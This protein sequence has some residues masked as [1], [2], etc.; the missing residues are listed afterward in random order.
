MSNIANATAGVSASAASG[1]K[2]NVF[3]NNVDTFLK[4]LTTQLKNQ[5]PTSPMDTTA[6]TSQLVQFSQ[7]EQMMNLGTSFKEVSGRIDDG[8][9]VQATNLVGRR[10]E[11]ETPAIS[12]AEGEARFTVHLD[13]PA[14]AT[15]VMVLDED[16]RVLRYLEGP[17]GA[18][19]HD[20]TWDGRADDGSLLPDGQY[21]V[22]ITS[23]SADGT[24]TELTPTVTTSVN[25]VTRNASGTQLL[26]GVGAV[27][28]A[29]LVGLVS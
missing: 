11:V 9:F 27:P 16:G 26:T 6:F 25:G 28:L 15:S 8:N 7:I 12:L 29:N 2:S 10:V 22:R 13:R 21:A 14:S 4:L 18:G 5:N 3:G 19:A 20:V 24:S 1:G 17:K 23:L